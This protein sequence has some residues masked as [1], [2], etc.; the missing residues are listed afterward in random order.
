MVE[1]IDMPAQVE[2]S[3]VGPTFSTPTWET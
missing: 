1:V 2:K 3:P